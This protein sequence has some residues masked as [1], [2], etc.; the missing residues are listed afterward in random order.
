V[1]SESLELVDKLDAL[2]AKARPVP[3]TDQVRVDA[4]EVRSL[5]EALRAAVEAELAEPGPGGEGPAEPESEPTRTTME[6]VVADFSSIAHRARFGNERF[7][8][9]MGGSPMVEIGP[10]GSRR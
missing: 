5:V 7:L 4:D 3:L 10:A 2:I 8:V 6:E 9:E 1:G